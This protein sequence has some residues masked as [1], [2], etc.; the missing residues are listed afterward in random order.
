MTR[1]RRKWLVPE[2]VQ[3][4]A[5]DCG[6]AS[7]KSLLEGFGVSVSYGRL[8][9]ACQTD[10]DG[11]S[12]DALE[13]IANQLGLR[14]EQ[15]MLPPD[16]VLLSAA[17][18]L[19]SL[20]VVRLP[21]GL[22]H[23]VVAWDHKAGLV[24]LMDP[25]TGRRWVTVKEFLASLYHHAMPVPM[26]GWRDWAL[27]DSFASCVSECLRE[28]G[29]PVATAER[30]VTQVR[31]EET[32]RGIATLDAATRMGRTLVQEG[33]LPRKVATGIIEDVVRRD[34]AGGGSGQLVPMRFWT[35]VPVD[36]TWESAEQVMLRGAVLLR[37]EGVEADVLSTSEDAG[38]ERSP[39][40]PMLAAALREKPERAWKE[41]L[42]V[43]REDG[44]ASPVMIA[45]ATVP[46]ALAVVLEAMVFKALLEM[47]WLLASPLQR[48]AALI[49]ILVLLLG[50][51]MLQWPI[52][53]GLLRLGRRL[54]VR[55]HTRFFEKI[56]K[57]G[58]RY[59]HSRLTSDMAD[60]SHGIQALR[61]VPGL[62]ADLLRTLLTLVF[63]TAGIAWLD[64]RALP[65]AL[66]VAVVS[67]V[68]PLVTQPML[69]ERDLRVRTHSGALMRH[70]LDGLRGLVAIRSHGAER[71]VRE[72]H[73]ALLVEWARSGLAMLRASVIVEAVIATV[74]FALAAVLLFGHALRAEEA[75]AVL[76]LLYWSLQLPQLGQQLATKARAYPSMRSTL[77]RVLE[78][79]RAPDENQGPN[80]VA[81][82]DTGSISQISENVLLEEKDA[83]GN[84]ARDGAE[85]ALE[86]VTA[87][88]GG[89]AVLTDVSLRL[90][91]GERVAIVGPSGAG[92]SSLVG[93]L[94]GWHKA[95]SG[96][97]RFDGRLIEEVGYDAVRKVTAWVDPSVQLWN[98]SLIGNLA[99]GAP[100][101]ATNALAEVVQAS[102]LRGVLQ[103][104]PAGMQTGLG[105]GGA[106]VSGGEGQRVRL[107]RAMLRRD[108]RLVILDE[109]FRGLERGRR[110]D[111]LAASLRWWADATVLCVSHD[112]TDTMAFDRVIVVDG[113]R[114][115]QD[116]PP[117]ELLEQQGPFR[118]LIEAERTVRDGLWGA[119]TWRR[120]RIEHGKVVEDAA[121]PVS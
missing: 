5:M 118:T 120:L 11:T 14:A 1:P 72:E 83:G 90:T 3:T 40:S 9:E 80:D 30:L 32:G 4:S 13:D 74:G 81:L 89:R 101:G 62:G 92:K 117:G 18:A 88:A 47:P 20:L 63:T 85:I 31:S 28:A 102:S 109:A 37:V 21:S 10:V 35:A 15:V 6:P 42:R 65:L 12:I 33:V 105:E 96:T 25:G 27:G 108:A 99:Y 44:L 54:E 107:G 17:E 115:V 95:A 112:V 24:Q 75:A 69:A 41:L 23:F 76:L 70:Y 38:G 73:E 29:V 55:F 34:L 46:A 19:P 26:E 45:V 100:R 87:L 36:G 59:F 116:G 66:V 51:L 39:L 110:R 48:L 84:H 78:P 64:V 77:L 68:L 91:P 7:L 86:G 53:A 97:V 50:I 2:V 8:R 93:L 82:G 104:L 52:T 121:E 61:T 94:L 60:R 43:L 67:M 22:T 119:G 98:R 49:A 106:L 16:F 58:D 114:I 56:P 57:L 111:L 113:G 103:R 71:F 79:L